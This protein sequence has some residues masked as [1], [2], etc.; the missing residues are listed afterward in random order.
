MFGSSSSSSPRDSGQYCPPTSRAFW[1]APFPSPYC[2]W[3]L[4]ISESCELEHGVVLMLLGSMDNIRGRNSRFN[5]CADGMWMPPRWQ[6]CQN[7]FPWLVEMFFRRGFLNRCA[8]PRIFIFMFIFS[9]DWRKKE[10]ACFLVCCAARFFFFFVDGETDIQIG[11]FVRCEPER[12]AVT[13]TSYRGD[14][15][16]IVRRIRWTLG[17]TLNYLAW[18]TKNRRNV[19]KGVHVRGSIT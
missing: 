4:N 17:W 11:L 14:D 3:V 2:H 19:R 6:N 1:A 12:G 13:S 15:D 5:A 7:L 9:T 16:A 10:F 18:V 8:A